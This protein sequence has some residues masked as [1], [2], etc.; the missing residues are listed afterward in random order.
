VRH[1]RACR[2]QTIALAIPGKHRPRGR[3]CLE[4]SRPVFPSTQHRASPADRPS[5]HFPPGRI[6]QSP[7]GTPT[8]WWPSLPSGAAGFQAGQ[9]VANLA[10]MDAVGA[11]G[12]PGAVAPIEAAVSLV[13]PNGSA[14]KL[15]TGPYKAAC[16]AYVA[17][18]ATYTKSL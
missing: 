2:A 12:A 4:Q 10:A 15:V 8:S 13:P 16:D 18:T 7:C 1:L 6:R 17:A 11:P 3:A 14:N 5:R 9:Q